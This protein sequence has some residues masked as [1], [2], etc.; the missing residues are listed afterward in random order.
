MLKMEPYR[1]LYFLFVWQEPHTDPSAPPD[2]RYRIEDAHTHEQHLFTELKNL[3][4][5][6]EREQVIFTPPI[7]GDSPHLIA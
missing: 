5:F 3:L 4:N 6:L 7:L 1:H 2:W